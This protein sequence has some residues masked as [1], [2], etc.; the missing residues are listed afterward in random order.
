MSFL[1]PRRGLEDILCPQEALSGWKFLQDALKNPDRSVQM[2]V[3]SKFKW[4]WYKN[5]WVLKN[6]TDPPPKVG[7]PSVC[8]PLAAVEKLE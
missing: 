5:I 1:A 2:D 4:K 8:N 3:F 6:R 7:D